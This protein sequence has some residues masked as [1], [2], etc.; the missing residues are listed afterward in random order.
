MIDL[1]IDPSQKVEKND[2][3]Q[4]SSI[5]QPVET[6]D[7]QTQPQKQ[8]RNTTSQEVSLAVIRTMQLKL[9]KADISTMQADM[10]ALTKQ[11]KAK[12]ESM[13]DEQLKAEKMAVLKQE[14][15]ELQTKLESIEKQIQ[16]KQD[17]I[18]NKADVGNSS[19]VTDGMN[20]LSSLGEAA[21][22]MDQRIDAANAKIQDSFMIDKSEI[23]S[24][25][26]S[27]ENMVVDYFKENASEPEI[28]DE[29]NAISQFDHDFATKIAERLVTDNEFVNSVPD[30]G[31]EVSNEFILEVMIRFKKWCKMILNRMAGLVI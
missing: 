4:M 30:K 2:P 27:D 11:L 12:Q 24:I 28:F 15:S 25:T 17:E 5:D 10:T 19:A 26:K 13:K 3:E 31:V 21:Q 18:R 14:A 20:E 6:S 22:A 7:D 23:D 8:S 9:K 16:L 1:L 29:L